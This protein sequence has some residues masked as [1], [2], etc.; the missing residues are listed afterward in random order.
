MD[1][2]SDAL[3]PPSAL[4]GLAQTLALY[5]EARLRL[6]QI[7][8][9]EAGGQIASLAFLAVLF[10]GSL[11]IAWMI[12]VPA[13]IWLIARQTAWHWSYIALITA[14]VHLLASFLTLLVLK[15]RLR[16]ARLFEESIRQF[17]HDRR[18]LAPTKS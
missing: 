1:S 5:V 13:L 17:Q 11:L 6:F 7:E 14:G 15:Q 4:R 18:W 12:A 16:K 2:S 10:V 9:Q 3:P 8:S